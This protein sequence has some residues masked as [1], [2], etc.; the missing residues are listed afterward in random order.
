MIPF[1]PKCGSTEFEILW[2]WPGVYSD[3]ECVNGHQ[4]TLKSSADTFS[5]AI[6]AAKEKKD[7]DPYTGGFDIMQQW[8][9]DQQKKQK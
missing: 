1:C 6:K 5:K 2:G 4:F 9:K 7:N 3:C 8:Q